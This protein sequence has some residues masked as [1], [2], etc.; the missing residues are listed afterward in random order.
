MSS[1]FFYNR[2][3]SLLLFCSRENFLKAREKCNPIGDSSPWEDYFSPWVIWPILNTQIFVK[4][5]S[6]LQIPNSLGDKFSHWDS[7][8]ETLITHYEKNAKWDHA[9]C[10]S[11]W[12]YHVLLRIYLIDFNFHLKMSWI[13]LTNFFLS[14]KE[15]KL[16]WGTN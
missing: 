2:E 13:Y 8:N 15:Q 5:N 14:F 11:L 9:K 3:I 10:F 1:I 6:T 4:T 7:Q 16:I 12:E